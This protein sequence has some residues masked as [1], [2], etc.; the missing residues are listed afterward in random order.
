MSKKINHNG[1]KGYK[2]NYK[3]TDFIVWNGSFDSTGDWYLDVTNSPYHF[4]ESEMSQN[5]KTKKGA[6]REMQYLINKKSNI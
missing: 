2:A 5:F 3:D 6:I 1:F 4:N